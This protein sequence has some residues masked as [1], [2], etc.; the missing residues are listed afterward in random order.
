M[1][2]QMLYLGPALVFFFSFQFPAALSLYW[3]VSTLLAWLQQKWIFS[4]R[5]KTSATV[6]Q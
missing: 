2:K 6:A 3:F 1:G 5:Q 4:Q